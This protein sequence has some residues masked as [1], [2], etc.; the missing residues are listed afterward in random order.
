MRLVANIP[1]KDN[2]ISLGDPVL[3]PGSKILN[4]SPCILFSQ[5]AENYYTQLC[6]ENSTFMLKFT[7][8]KNYLK[9][10]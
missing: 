4:T 10:S 2:Y 7:N 3:I 8:C 9:L 1:N 5:K 6:N